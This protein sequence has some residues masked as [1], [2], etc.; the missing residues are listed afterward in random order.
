[1][2][3]VFNQIWK[4]YLSKFQNIQF[5]DQIVCFSQARFT[6]SATARLF[7]Y[8]TAYQFWNTS[9][10]VII[11][12]FV[13][14]FTWTV[15]CTAQQCFLFADFEPAWWYWS[16][17]PLG[18]SSALTLEVTQAFVSSKVTNMLLARM[19]TNMATFSNLLLVLA[20]LQN[21]APLGAAPNSL[22][23][24][25]VMILFKVLWLLS[26]ISGGWNWW[27]THLQCDNRG[28]QSSSLRWNVWFRRPHRKR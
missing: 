6:G 13:L 7:I 1:M 24:I 22:S 25:Q 11:L 20:L 3:T 9:I 16:V 12:Y 28:R 15:N 5:N 8:V 10:V 23:T 4:Q 14:I 19:V 17:R 21:L 26:L 18:L 27:E 2:K